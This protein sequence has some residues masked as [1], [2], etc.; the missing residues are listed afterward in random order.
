VATNQTEAAIEELTG[1]NQTVRVSRNVALNNLDSVE[2]FL[3]LE[4]FPPQYEVVAS[5]STSLRNR[6]LTITEWVYDNGNL[7]IV[8]ESANPLDPTFYIETFEK[9]DRFSNA[10]GTSGARQNSLRLSMQVVAQ[11]WLAQ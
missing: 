9:S 6:N 11:E 1:A 3:S 7:D 10:S 2:S 8:V 4:T 5:A